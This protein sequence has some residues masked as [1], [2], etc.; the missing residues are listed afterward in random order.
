MGLLI[1]NIVILNSG[2]EEIYGLLDQIA[3]FSDSRIKVH[4]VFDN[5]KVFDAE[6]E[7]YDPVVANVMEYSNRGIDL[8][9][10]FFS[11]DGDF[12]QFRNA[13]H[14]QILRGSWVLHLDSDERVHPEFFESI[15]A[16]LNRMEADPETYGTTDLV[17]FARENKVSGITKDYV[18]SLGWK[19]D[20]KGRVNYPD[21]QGRLYRLTDSISWVGKVHERIQGF[22]DYSVLHDV[23]SDGEL[24]NKFTILHHKTMERQL[25]QNSLYD[26]MQ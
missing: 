16:M 4:V 21:L 15:L 2:E 17:W 7:H 25:K 14:S 18:N 13:I 9:V 1:L 6:K 26:S 20:S 5:P 12:S 11:L 19:L 23:Q 10:A 3:Q 24:T 8:S 22:R